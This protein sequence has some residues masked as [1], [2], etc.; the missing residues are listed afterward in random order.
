ML[1][2]SKKLTLRGQFFYVWCAS[3][4]SVQV[5]VAKLTVAQSR[6]LESSGPSFLSKC[7]RAQRV[8]AV[9]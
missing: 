2:E 4:K 1:V 6:F 9:A 8:G 7:A 3:Q 5:I